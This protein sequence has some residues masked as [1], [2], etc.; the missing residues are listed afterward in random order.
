MSDLKAA[1]NILSDSKL[2]DAL[3]K[4]LNEVTVKALDAK[5]NDQPDFDGVLKKNDD[6]STVSPTERDEAFRAVTDV[7]AGTSIQRNKL[8]GLNPSAWLQKTNS[9]IE[10]KMEAV[11]KTLSE[12]IA[13]EG[14]TKLRHEL[15]QS[16]LKSSQQAIDE[17]NKLKITDTAPNSKQKIVEENLVTKGKDKELKV[18][19]HETDKLSIKDISDYCNFILIYTKTKDYLIQRSKFHLG[20]KEENFV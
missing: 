20:E 11:R 19:I 6:K 14:K 2:K 8:L 16:M 1:V 18:T 9:D 13:A 3:K 4:T 12:E 5:L 17:W 15:V 7:L 10:S